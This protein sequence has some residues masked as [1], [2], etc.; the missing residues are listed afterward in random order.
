MGD[1]A[2]GA[3]DGAWDEGLGAVDVLGREGGIGG[4]LAGVRAAC[5]VG[6]V[7]RGVGVRAGGGRTVVG[8]CA[9]GLLGATGCV[10]AGVRD[11]RGAGVLVG[12]DG[13]VPDVSGAGVRDGRGDGVGR[14]MVPEAEGLGRGVPPSGIASHTPTPTP[15]STTTAAPAV[16]H[17]ALRDWRR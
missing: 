12:A 6:C 3:G 16:I 10:L 2:W 17:G 4:V 8:R 9:D 7:V 15:A 1:G 13:V 14:E 5:G 11:G